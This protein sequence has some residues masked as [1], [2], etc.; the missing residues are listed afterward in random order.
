MPSARELAGA[1]AARRPHATELAELM[2]N[3]PEDD[4][5][6]RVI[7]A[8]AGVAD[9]AADEP[10]AA[11]PNSGRNGNRTSGRTTADAGPPVRL[12]SGTT[13][14]GLRLGSESPAS[15]PDQCPLWEFADVACNLE[16]HA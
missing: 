6:E 2:I 5:R 13:D 12:A 15:K 7:D 8:L 9:A 4:E 14:C 16:P 10:D 11:S 3:A 1:V